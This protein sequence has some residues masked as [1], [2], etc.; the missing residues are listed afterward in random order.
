MHVNVSLYKRNGTDIVVCPIGR[1]HRSIN[2]NKET[3]DCYMND[4]DRFTVSGR[5]PISNRSAD[6]VDYMES[7]CVVE[8][9]KMCDFVEVSG[10]LLRTV[11]AIYENVATADRCKEICLASKEFQCRSFDYNETGVNVCR[12]SH[13]STSSLSQQQLDHRPYLTVVG[14]TTYQMSSCFSVKIDCRSADMVASVHTNRL[15]DGKVYAKNRP[16]SCVND[17]KS[18]LDFD[19][20]LDYHSPNCDVRQDQPGKFFTEI[21]IQVKINHTYYVVIVGFSQLLQCRLRIY[22][23]CFYPHTFF[24][25][26]K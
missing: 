1:A 23:K 21:I 12:V 5:P 26:D 8:Q 17:V 22:R 19:L 2:F 3:G 6:V 9:P 18:T 13:H 24:S 10:K 15:F 20:R 25:Y 14:A 4:V 16:S 11:D 7:N